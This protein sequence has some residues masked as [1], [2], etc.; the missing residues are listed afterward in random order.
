[1]GTTPMLRLLVIPVGMIAL[2]IGSMI[3]S[4][5]GTERRAELTFINRGEIG[6]LDPNRMSWLQDI[7]AGS[8]LYEGLYTL[9]PM[10]LDAVPGCSDRL[11]VSADKTVYTFHIRDNARW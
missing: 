2:L 3:W 5:G 8:C 4:G 7:R 1:M 11:D 9:D 6:T 10:T